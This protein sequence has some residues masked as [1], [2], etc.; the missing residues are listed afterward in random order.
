[1][2]TRGKHLAASLAFSLFSHGLV[3]GLLALVAMP[4]APQDPP[5]PG[6]RA[7]DTPFPAKL[8]AYRPE[9]FRPASQLRPVLSS[10][11]HLIGSLARAPQG[12]SRQ[13]GKNES[14]LS[15]VA[16]EHLKRRPASQPIAAAPLLNPEI[17]QILPTPKDDSW[18]DRNRTER[19]DRRLYRDGVI[20]SALGQSPAGAGKNLEENSSDSIAL[21]L[22][23]V[24]PKIK[25]DGLDSFDDAA[26]LDV[27]SPLALPQLNLESTDRKSVV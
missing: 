20:D 16:Q 7:K 11:E 2:R 9:E 22:K 23:G 13:P 6:L 14:Q 17:Y 19:V 15:G 4:E 5:K 27:S 21:A 3:F 10:R 18:S 8:L 25:I 1:M 26:S 12:L 24:R